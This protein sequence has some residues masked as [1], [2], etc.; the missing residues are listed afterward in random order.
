MPLS[1]ELGPR[2][3]QCGLGQGLLPYQAVSSSIQPFGHNRHWPKLGR[4]GFAVLSGDSWVHI[5][6]NVENAE[7]YLRTKWHLDRCSR[8]ATIDV[9]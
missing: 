5:E 2:L 9:D 6:H 8:L 3:V 1:R 4:G 7:A